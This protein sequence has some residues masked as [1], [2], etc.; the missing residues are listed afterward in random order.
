MDD[1]HKEP[2]DGD[3]WG[4]RDVFDCR[5][6]GDAGKVWDSVWGTSYAEFGD[7]VMAELQ[8]RQDRKSDKVIR[9]MRPRTP[10]K[11]PKPRK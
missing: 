4:P 8:D 2:K 10:S 7:I 1:D 6:D 9:K 3:R 5:P 11:K